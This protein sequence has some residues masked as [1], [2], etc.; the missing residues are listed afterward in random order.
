MLTALKRPLLADVRR[1]RRINCKARVSY[2]DMRQES[3]HCCRSSSM[4]FNVT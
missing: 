4:G 3:T 2:S 1:K